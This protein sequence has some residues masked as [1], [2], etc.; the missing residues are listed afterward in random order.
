VGLRIGWG[1]CKPEVILPFHNDL[2][3]FLQHLDDQ[4]KGL[5]YIV[6]VFG[7]CLGVPRHVANDPK[8]NASSLQSLGVRHD[9]LLDLAESVVDED[10]FAALRLLQVCGVQRFGHIISAVPPPL[11]SDFAH[12]RDDALTATLAAIQHKPPS[13]DSTHSLPVGTGGATI[14]SIA[15]HA[16]SSYLGAFFRVAAPMH[17]RLVAMGGNTN[18]FVVMM[19]INPVHVAATQHWDA[20]VCNAHAD[21][22]TLKHS[23]TVAEH[24]TANVMAPRGTII[25]T[26]G[27]PSAI[28]QDLPPTIHPDVT[29]TLDSSATTP[30][31]VRYVIAYLRKLTE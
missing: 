26:A 9:R 8:F 12:S 21:A 22:L 13:Q 17:Q 14:T 18:R 31:G 16:A 7:A 27:D 29:P 2:E 30:K 10:P 5:P 19:M 28:A 4:T 6:P 11:V 20:F 3:S 25:T 24:T 15:R 1:P 23:F